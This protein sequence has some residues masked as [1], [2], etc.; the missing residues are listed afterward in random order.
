MKQTL[1]Q[2]KSSY[3]PAIMKCIGG[4]AAKAE[5]VWSM[6][7]HVLSEHRASL[8]PLVFEL[9]MYLKYNTRL[10]SLSDV[11]EANK[12]TK[13]ESPAAKMRVVAQKERLNNT[14]AEVMNWDQGIEI[15]CLNEE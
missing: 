5:F 15:D 13:N 1:Q 7:G 8:S 11:A 10:W 2:F 4:S 3:D 9:I 12:R 6:A 14:R